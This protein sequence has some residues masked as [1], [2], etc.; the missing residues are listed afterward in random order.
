MLIKKL[1]K[2]HSKSSNIEVKSGN[3]R[4]EIIE[5]LI[6]SLPRRYQTGLEKLMKGSNFAFDYKCR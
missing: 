5:N 1:N 6:Y 4:Y 2:M 3:K